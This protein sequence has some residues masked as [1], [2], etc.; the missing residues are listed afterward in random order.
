MMQNATNVLLGLAVMVISFIGNIVGS[1]SS[2]FQWTLVIIGAVIIVIS[3]WG[4][5]EEVHRQAI[6]KNGM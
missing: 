1:V 5:A 6:V 3:L 4:L 2:A